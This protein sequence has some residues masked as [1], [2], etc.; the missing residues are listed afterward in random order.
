[1]EAVG[2]RTGGV[3]LGHAHAHRGGDELACEAVQAA[4]PGAAGV[5]GCQEPG[6][7]ECLRGSTGVDTGTDERQTAIQ[8]GADVPLGV[9]APGR[10]RRIP[11][12][13]LWA[14]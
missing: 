14:E 11:D 5:L 13:S 9:T 2:H 4:G 6:H 1:M 10:Y 3:G 8:S 12:G 7:P